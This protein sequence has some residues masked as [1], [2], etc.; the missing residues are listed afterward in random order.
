M[1]RSLAGARDAGDAER[2]QM[3]AFGHLA[4]GGEQRL[5]L[6]HHAPGRRRASA[7]FIRP[8]ASAGVDGRQT[9]RPGT[10]AHIG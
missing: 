9:I 7:V 1:V 8:L 6:Q 3:L 5:H 2:H 4:L 10:C